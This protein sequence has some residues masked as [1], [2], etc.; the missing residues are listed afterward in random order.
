MRQGWGERGVRAWA[1]GGTV[2]FSQQAGSTTEP[3]IS[4]QSS[5]ATL[6]APGFVPMTALNQS[7]GDLL[8]AFRTGKSAYAVAQ[9][10]A[11]DPDAI[12]RQSAAG[13]RRRSLRDQRGSAPRHH[14]A[15]HRHRRADRGSHP[16]SPRR[17]RPRHCPATAP[18]TAT[19]TNTATHTATPTATLPPTGDA[20]NDPTPPTSPTP[21]IT[22]DCVSGPYR[23]YLPFVQASNTG[24][25]IILIGCNSGR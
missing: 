18:A 7:Y 11:A 16:P 4:E 19:A 3:I 13:T 5:Y 2:Q 17:Q 12:R 20:L 8:Q 21:P 1:C 6:A 23:V 14:R 22:T 9:R 10:L 15:R 24:N 25:T